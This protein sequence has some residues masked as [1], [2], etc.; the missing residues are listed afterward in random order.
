MEMEKIINASGR[1]MEVIA[2]GVALQSAQND[3]FTTGDIQS[4]RISKLM[5]DALKENLGSCGETQVKKVLASAIAIAGKNGILPSGMQFDNSLQMAKAV[6]MA[7][8]RTKVAYQNGAGL[9]D[10]TEVADALI[11]KAAVQLSVAVDRAFESG[12]V[13]E[14]LANAAVGVCTYFGFPQAS[15]YKP[16]I[17]HAIKR[18]EP[19]LRSVVQKG[20]VR[21]RDWAKSS[22]RNCIQTTKNYAS[23][24]MAKLFA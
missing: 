6:D 11:D 2:D 21:C 1:L 15:V 17:K 19:A 10:A 3:D 9:M 24:V 18:F 8:T 22:L 16:V 20:M 5:E 14:M 12:Q 7:V 13:N 4:G 23:K